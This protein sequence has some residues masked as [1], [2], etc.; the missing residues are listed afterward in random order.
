MPL[1]FP[2]V[3]ECSEIIAVGIFLRKE[4]PAFVERNEL[5]NF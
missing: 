4:L 5:P 2:A 3:Q 1:A